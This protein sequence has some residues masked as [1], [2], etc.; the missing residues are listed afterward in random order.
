VVK[1]QAIDA[2]KQK[3]VFWKKDLRIPLSAFKERRNGLCLEI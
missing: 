2:M 1:R 3:K